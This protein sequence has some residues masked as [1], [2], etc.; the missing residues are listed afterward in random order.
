[1]LKTNRAEVSAGGPAS[2]CGVASRS[3]YVVLGA[4]EGITSV[5]VCKEPMEVL[6]RGAEK[7]VL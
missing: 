3:R 1:M 6:Y 2:C 7:M 5:L 4:C